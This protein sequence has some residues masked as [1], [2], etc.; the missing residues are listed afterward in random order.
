[1]ITAAENPM[2]D[3]LSSPEFVVAPTVFLTCKEL[4]RRLRPAV[5]DAAIVH[6][7]GRHGPMWGGC[8][9]E[10]Q[11]GPVVLRRTSCNYPIHYTIC[12]AGCN[13]RICE[14]FRVA[15]LPI[16]YKA[17]CHK[18][19]IINDISFT[20]I[21]QVDSIEDALA[22]LSGKRWV[23]KVNLSVT[24]RNGTV[25]MYNRDIQ[26]VYGQAPACLTGRRYVYTLVHPDSRLE[27]LIGP[28][29]A[30]ML[31]PAVDSVA[32]LGADLRSTP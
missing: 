18:R 2:M 23:S 20:C 8:R 26:P 5:K 11:W 3:I 19:D 16:A 32:Y 4:Y 14:V 30:Y 12:G 29:L 6:L 24:T 21:V 27:P 9:E 22:V 31:S 10:F 28:I 25:C 17:Y 13:H 7:L 1:M 15:V